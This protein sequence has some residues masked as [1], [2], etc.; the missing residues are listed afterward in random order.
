MTLKTKSLQKGTDVPWR[1]RFQD[2]RVAVFHGHLRK[3][4]VMLQVNRVTEL[5][6]IKKRIDLLARMSRFIM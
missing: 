6:G 5:W 2:P 1:L 4:S 3:V